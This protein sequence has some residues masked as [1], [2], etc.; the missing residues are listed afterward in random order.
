MTMTKRL[1]L[2]LTAAILATACSREQVPAGHALSVASPHTEAA[3]REVAQSLPLSDAQDFEDARRGLVATEPSLVIAG[4]DGTR[5]WDLASYDFVQGDAPASVNP[6]LWRQA[7]AQQHPRPVR[8]RTEGIYQ[9]RGYDLVQHDA[10]P[11]SQRLDR[12]RSAHDRRRL[13]PRRCALA[14]KHL[15]DR[16][17][18]RRDLHAQPCRSLR[19]RSAPC[20]RSDADVRAVPIVAPEGFMRGSDQRERARRRRRWAAALTTCPRRAI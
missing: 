2:M 5:Y 4:P 3:N 17:D 11:G 12:R 6:S 10:D 18:H 7:Q 15:G 19:R 13:R 20:C 1:G 14:R 8:G 9:V 16:S